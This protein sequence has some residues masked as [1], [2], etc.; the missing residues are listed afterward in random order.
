M[1]LLERHLFSGESNRSFQVC[2]CGNYPPE[3]LGICGVFRWKSW[4]PCGKLSRVHG[5]PKLVAYNL[6]QPRPRGRK[7]KLRPN[8]IFSF[9]ARIYFERILQKKVSTTKLNKH[10]ARVSL[11]IGPSESFAALSVRCFPSVLYK[12]IRLFFVTHGSSRPPETGPLLASRWARESR[13][14]PPKG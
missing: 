10:Y 1:E 7:N 11:H 9:H 2:F 4:S 14:P 3:V 8:V 12:T 13:I 6:V 5:Q